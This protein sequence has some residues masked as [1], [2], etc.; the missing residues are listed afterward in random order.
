[1]RS[2]LRFGIPPPVIRSPRVAP[3]HHPATTIHRTLSGSTT[4]CVWAGG[5][6]G[7][8]SS[9]RGCGFQWG[10]RRRGR[11]GRKN[12]GLS[13]HLLHAPW[14]WSTEF[15]QRDWEVSGSRPSNESAPEVGHAAESEFARP[16][17]E[18]PYPQS[19]G[20]SRKTLRS[21][22]GCGPLPSLTSPRSPGTTR[23][24]PLRQHTPRPALLFSFCFL[25]TKPGTP[26]SVPGR[27]RTPS[28]CFCTASFPL[29]HQRTAGFPESGRP[30][31]VTGRF[32]PGSNLWTV[33]VYQ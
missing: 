31:R 17:G 26:R 32:P 29:T 16:P 22:Q 27:R 5:P 6:G 3:R 12:R 15:S 30:Q 18:P 4:P 33:A 21:C 10:C 1:V 2:S 9:S 20:A 23:P 13:L 28:Q 19:P 8:D 11:P 25:V 7:P 24:L 14:R